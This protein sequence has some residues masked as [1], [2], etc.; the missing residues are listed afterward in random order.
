ML[1]T[2]KSTSVQTERP[3]ETEIIS[4][5]TTGVTTPQIANPELSTQQPSTEFSK[6]QFTVEETTI[7]KITRAPGGISTSK[8]TETA[9]LTSK[10][11]T[12][13]VVES[14]PAEE[15]TV[16]VAT[17]SGFVITSGKA[18]TEVTTEL[19]PWNHL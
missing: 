14:T 2:E 15:N 12:E 6:S 17:E 19:P 1:S 4:Q 3:T 11:T 13:K 5:I 7:E 9:E 18:E 10:V 16:K 8:T